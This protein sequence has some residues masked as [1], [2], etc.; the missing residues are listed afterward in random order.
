MMF[1]R[2]SLWPNSLSYINT[3]RQAAASASA[4]ALKFWRLGWWLGMGQGPILKHHNVFQW[5][6]AAAADAD[7]D[8]DDAAWRSVCLHP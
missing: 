5:D 6:L 2:Q 4:A 1:V 7:D 8:D 3:E